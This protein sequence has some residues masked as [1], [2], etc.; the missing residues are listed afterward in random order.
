MKTNIEVEI[1]NI[2]VDDFYYTFNYKVTVDGKLKGEGEYNNDHAWIDDKEGFIGLLE[3][4]Y[5]VGL[6]LEQVFDK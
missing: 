4:G 3:E 6:A 1:T 2:E 5:A